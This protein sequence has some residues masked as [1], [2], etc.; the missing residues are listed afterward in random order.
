M[1]ELFRVTTEQ[2]LNDQ[3]LFYGDIEQK[4]ELLEKNFLSTSEKG[5]HLIGGHSWLILVNFQVQ[6]CRSLNTEQQKQN[7]LLFSSAALLPRHKVFW[8]RSSLIPADL[9]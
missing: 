5:H 6:K 2:G 9:F 4:T 8:Q 7:L 3:E 1:S